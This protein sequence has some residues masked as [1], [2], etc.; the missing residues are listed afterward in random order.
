MRRQMRYEVQLQG[1]VIVVIVKIGIVIV[2]ITPSSWKIQADD[3][4]DQT[5]IE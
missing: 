5:K 4:V 1:V 3:L 2:V